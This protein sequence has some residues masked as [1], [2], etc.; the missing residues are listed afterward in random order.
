MATETTEEKQRREHRERQDREQ[1]DDPHK[2]NQTSKER[3]HASHQDQQK[4]DLHRGVA[5]QTQESKPPPQPGDNGIEEIPEP[6]DAP[7]V[8]KSEGAL[9]PDLVKKEANLALH[10]MRP[11]PRAAEIEVVLGVMFNDTRTHDEEFTD[12]EDVR[13]AAIAK[14]KEL[15]PLTVAAQEGAPSAASGQVVV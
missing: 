6:L 8:G 1:R 11:Q 13:E 2:R 9:D 3:E 7:W 10:A 5:S 14:F 12:K 4:R 15:F